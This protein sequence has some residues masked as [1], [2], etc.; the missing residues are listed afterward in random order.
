MI[1]TLASSLP[2]FESSFFSSSFA[3]SLGF[4]PG[5]ER[6][7]GL[8]LTGAAAGVSLMGGAYKQDQYG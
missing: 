4:R 6:A 5:A 8:D 7:L 3:F 2:F 1:I